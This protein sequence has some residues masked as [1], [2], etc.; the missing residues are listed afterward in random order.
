LSLLTGEHASIKPR[1]FDTSSFTPPPTSRNQKTAFPPHVH[2]FTHKQTTTTFTMDVNIIF[3][4]TISAALRKRNPTCKS[5]TNRNTS[6]MHA[7][8]AACEKAETTTTSAENV[9]KDVDTTIPSNN[10]NGNEIAGESVK[11]G[12]VAVKEGEREAVGEPKKYD[13]VV[14]LLGGQ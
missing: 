8:T 9:S 11:S 4:G 5:N 7:H 6:D 2:K 14:D 3:T 13:A 12:A 1:V 10:N